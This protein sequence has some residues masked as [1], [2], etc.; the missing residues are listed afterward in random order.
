MNWL[1]I[2]IIIII[3]FSGVLGFKRGV[4]KELIL[5]AGIIL[6]FIL[7]YTLKNYI[8]DFLVLNFPFFD[9]A[10]GAS[11]LNIILYPF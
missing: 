2:V 3:L 4:F 10:N 8:G 5:F 7:S 11:A 1:D 9:F 6:V